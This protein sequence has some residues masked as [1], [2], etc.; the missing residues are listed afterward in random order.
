MPFIFDVAISYVTPQGSLASRLAAEL[1]ARGLQVF[2]DRVDIETIVGRDGPDA[3][4]QVYAADSRVCVL[5]L[6]PAYDHSPWTALERSAIFRRRESDRSAFLIPV[7]VEGTEPVWLP[8]QLLY[9]DL[10]RNSEPKL[11]EVIVNRVKRVQGVSRSIPQL[12]KTAWVGIGTF[13]NEIIADG[14][15]LY[16]PT[17]GRKH[18][19]PDERDGIVCIRAADLSEVWHAHTSHD[20]NAILQLDSSLYIGTDAGT[21]ECIDAASGEV[22]WHE[23][24]RLSAP[25]LARPIWT[26]G[27]VL[28]CAVNGEAALIDRDS[29]AILENAVF[30]GG[31]VGDPLVIS[32]P[33]EQDRIL[34]ATG[35]G[36]VIEAPLA[37]PLRGADSESD[38]QVRRVQATAKG[39]GDA[40]SPCIFTGSP[41]RLEGT[42]FLPHAR[43]T[44]L[45]GLP[46]AALELFRFRMLYSIAEL[47]RPRDDYGNV[48]ARPAVANGLVVV[49]T[50][51]SN[52]SVAFDR[53]GRIAWETNCGWPSFQQYGSP[54]AFGLDVLVPRADGALHAVDT[55]NGRRRWS[56]ALGIDGSEGEVFFGNEELPGE[57]DSPGWEA[58]GRIALNAPVTVVGDVAYLVDSIGNL[59]AVGLPRDH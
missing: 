1:E 19:V 53:D 47:K 54:A 27:A 17:A 26:G 16:V 12:L 25:V 9:F 51:Y 35:E 39:F 21:I 55:R 44:Y 22:R 29:G 57:R 49:P 31:V 11:L 5:L 58:A 59:H 7:R 42:V 38:A 43:E 48:R 33:G 20:S 18:N 3:L 4:A 34:F 52:L 56:I 2:Y 32:E 41:A 6:S 50:A 46:V 40:T 37:E 13:K 23:P 15:W 8:R 14:E 36:W 24:P 10:Q 45:E 30:P 28:A